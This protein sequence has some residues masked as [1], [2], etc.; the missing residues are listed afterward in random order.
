MADRLVRIGASATGDIVTYTGSTRL[1]TVTVDG[2]KVAWAA[3]GVKVALSADGASATGQVLAVGAA[4]PT[5]GAGAPPPDSAKSV[6]VTIS[7]DPQDAFGSV[8]GT[9]VSVR[10][11]LQEH[12]DVLTV[13]VN[14]LLALAEGGYGV[15]LVGNGSSHIVAVQVGL[16][17]DGRVEIQD[18]GLHDGDPV[19]VPT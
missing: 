18:D 6:R 5:T 2:S 9:S 3:N 17:A 14:A 19:G 4:S 15:E 1:V 16:F 7:F 12:K 10:Y 8:V 11:V 13:P